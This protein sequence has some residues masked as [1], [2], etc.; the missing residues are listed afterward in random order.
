VRLFKQVGCEKEKFPKSNKTAISSSVILPNECPK[1]FTGDKCDKVDACAKNNPCK[2]GNICSLDKNLKPTC[3]CPLGYQGPKCDKRSCNVIEF[4]GNHFEKSPKVYINKDKMRNFQD[5]DNLAK[6]CS[7]LIYAS[8]S[9]SLQANPNNQ[10]DNQNAP[11]YTGNGLEIELHDLKGRLYCNS[12]C[13]GKQPTPLEKAKC[14]TDG[15]AAIGWRHSIFDAGIIHD[16]LHVTN[17]VE[18]EKLRQAQQVGCKE[19][20]F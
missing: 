11:F 13:L 18:Y 17:P 15:L 4:K 19:Q 20:K 2:D 5:L 7:V 8:R 1:G 3:T 16:G 9:F 6:N 14:F 10:V 12:F